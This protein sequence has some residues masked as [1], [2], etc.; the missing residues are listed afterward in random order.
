MKSTEVREYRSAEELLSSIDEDINEL[1]RF[2]AENIRKLEL[3]RRKLDE[4]KNIKQ[5]IQKIFPQYRPQE[6]RGLV[7]LKEIQIAI[8]PTLENEIESLEKM[9]DLINQKLNVL[10]TI[11]KDLDALTQY[12]N[13]LR[14]TVYYFDGIPRRVHIYY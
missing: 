6:N 2:L 3:M 7:T 11:R 9:L 13:P 5:M 8:G 1:K 10:I 14:I 12:K 4:H